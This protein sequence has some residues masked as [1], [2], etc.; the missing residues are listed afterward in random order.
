MNLRILL[1]VLFVCVQFFAYSA[2][3]AQN[4][5]EH[6]LTYKN[7]QNILIDYSKNGMLNKSSNDSHF[8][9]Q[10]FSQK[11]IYNQRTQ[12]NFFFSSYVPNFF[13]VQ[14]FALIKYIHNNSNLKEQNTFIAYQTEINRRAP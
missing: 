1:T 2:Y 8:V 13:S 14:Y 11:F 6:P 9:I 3:C 7:S 12:N 4:S 10:N 5:E